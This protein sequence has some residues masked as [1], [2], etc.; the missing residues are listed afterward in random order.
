MNRPD[1]F[2][3]H[4]ENN[5]I[6]D[7]K[8]KKS[9]WTSDNSVFL[10]WISLW[11]KISF[12]YYLWVGVYSV[13]W[14][15]IDIYPD[16]VLGNVLVMKYPKCKFHKHQISKIYI[17][18]ALEAEQREWKELKYNYLQEEICPFSYRSTVIRLN[19]KEAYFFTFYLE[20]RNLLFAIWF[21]LL[22][23]AVYL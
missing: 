18:Q 21:V 13:G 9:R 16:V 8:R 3:Y 12:R 5:N 19:R 17:L 7:G 23:L 11:C 2:S 6:L 1:L 22:P 20:N 15:E 4:L 14:V 10:K